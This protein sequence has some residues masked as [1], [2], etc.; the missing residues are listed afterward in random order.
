MALAK[1]K[2]HLRA[3]AIRTN[4]ALWKVIGDICELFT[5]P[6]VGTTSMPPDMNSHESP[7]L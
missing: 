2:A 6:N 7:M 3:G 4:A 5:L 1:L